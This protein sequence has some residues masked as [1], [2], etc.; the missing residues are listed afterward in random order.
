MVADDTAIFVLLLYHWKPDMPDIYLCSV[1]KRSTN[2]SLPAFNIRDTVQKYNS[3][4]LKSLLAIHAWGG[5]HTTSSV[6]GHGKCSI[7][8][9]IRRSQ[10]V[11]QCFLT[12]G[13]VEATKTDIVRVGT[14][15]CYLEYMEYIATSKVQLQPERQ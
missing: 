11:V 9:V 3:D 14:T 13:D 5:T 1:I 8:K 12:L 4:I 6:Y 7:L 2:K 15:V 10:D